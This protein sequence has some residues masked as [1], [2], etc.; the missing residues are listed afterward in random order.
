M[1][2]VRNGK[3]GTLES[4]SE[5][6]GSAGAYM[7]DPRSSISLKIAL[8]VRYFIFMEQSSCSSYLGANN[9]AFIQNHKS[10]TEHK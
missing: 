10:L 8:V 1:N 4:L 6:D 9:P 7:G 5:L 3:K 2:R